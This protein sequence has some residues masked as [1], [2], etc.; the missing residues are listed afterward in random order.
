MSVHLAN[1]AMLRALAEGYLE[2]ATECHARAM[3]ERGAELE[4]QAAV[5]NRAAEILEAKQAEGLGP[6][7]RGEGKR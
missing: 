4:L 7:R 5:H 6:D 1:I 2:A 3:T